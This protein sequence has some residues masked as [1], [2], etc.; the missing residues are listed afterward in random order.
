M[1]KRVQFAIVSSVA[2]LLLSGCHSGLPKAGTDDQIPLLEKYEKQGRHDKAIRVAQDWLKNHNVDPSR[3][4]V[5]YE[6][7]AFTYLKKAAKDPTHK[8]E[9]IRQATAYYDKDL[10]VHQKQ[11]ADIELYTVGR[12]F[13]LAGDLAT[14]DACQSYGQAIKDFEDETPFIQGD[15]VTSYGHTF[16]LAPVREENSKALERAKTKF[17]G[18]GCH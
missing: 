5:F 1:L 2:A 14:A 11:E 16:K 4:D 12:G 7:V 3:M 17:A 15:S 13:E 18:H 10:A 8:D 6:Q 9:F